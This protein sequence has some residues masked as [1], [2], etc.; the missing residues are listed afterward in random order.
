VCKF[1]PYKTNRTPKYLNIA[2][3]NQQEK[4]EKGPVFLPKGNG[5][6]WTLN[7]GRWEAWLVLALILT[8]LVGGVVWSSRM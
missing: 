1:K 2:Y 4:E 8:V 5:L 7:F 6:G 3:M